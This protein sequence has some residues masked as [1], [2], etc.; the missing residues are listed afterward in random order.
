MTEL[1]GDFRRALDYA[2]DAHAGQTRKGSD[3]PYVAHLLGVAALVLE[4]GGDETEAIAAL[5]HDV[6]EDQGGEERL[7]DVRERFGG[8]VAEIVRACSDTLVRPK[9]PWHERKPAYVE[10]LRETDDRSV[11][12]VSAADKLHNAR[13]VLADL[14]AQGPAV[15][16]RFSAPVDDQLWYYRTLADAYLERLPGPLAEELDRVVGEIQRR[17]RADGEVDAGRE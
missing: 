2:F 10:H 17:A 16:D 14:Q 15:W 8:R 13:A 3:I 11:L 1:G 6:A 12:L 5:L 7:A 4:A 9:P